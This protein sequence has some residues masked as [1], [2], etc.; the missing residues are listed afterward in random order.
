M[1]QAVGDK[2]Q[3][4]QKFAGTPS[5]GDCLGVEDLLTDK[6]NQRRP[7]QKRRQPHEAVP[8]GAPGRNCDASQADGIS[9]VFRPYP[10]FARFQTEDPGNQPMGGLVDQD[11]RQVD[12]E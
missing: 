10:K 11:A 1:G 7:D 8:H 3:P 2:G 5:E 4:V 9:G 12:Q 6:H